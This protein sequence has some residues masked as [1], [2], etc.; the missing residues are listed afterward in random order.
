[1]SRNRRM[2][3]PVL[4]FGALALGPSAE[5]AVVD[6]QAN[7]FTVSQSVTIAAPPAK[8]W[9]A[10]ARIG[11]WW[12]PV[13]SY[14]RDGANLSISLKPGGYWQEALPGGGV[15]H[16]VVVNAQPGK[17]LRLAGALGPLQAYGV[18]GELSLA[19]KESPGGTI[20][21]QTYDVGGHA[22][23]GLDKL[24]PPVDAVL[25]DQLGRLKQFV[26]ASPAR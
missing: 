24:A 5:C 19:L 20:V 10:L 25:G 3:F 15:L 7:G 26:E 1:M 18:A 2:I 21:T 4:A 22:P 12:D 11:A 6:A 8:V 17:L 9:E 23:G 16:M 13:H 14:S